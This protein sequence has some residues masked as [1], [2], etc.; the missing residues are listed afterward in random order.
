LLCVSAHERVED[1]EVALVDEL[2][3]LG[4]CVRD[5]LEEPEHPAR[6]EFLGP[7]PGDGQR[8]A[9][10]VVRRE[11]PLCAAE[12]TLVERRDAPRDDRLFSVTAAECKRP[13]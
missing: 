9:V 3:D 6:A 11:E 1:D 12:V 4:A 5:E 7:V 13:V 8:A 2:D 10:D